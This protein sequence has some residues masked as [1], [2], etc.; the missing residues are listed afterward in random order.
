MKPKETTFQGVRRHL[1]NGYVILTTRGVVALYGAAMREAAKIVDSPVGVFLAPRDVF[2]DGPHFLRE[3]GLRATIGAMLRQTAATYDPP[4]GRRRNPVNDPL[5]EQ[6]INYYYSYDLT[7]PDGVVPSRRPANEMD[8]ALETPFA[9]APKP[10]RERPIAAIVHGFYPEIAPL[11]L[12]KLKNVTGPVD[13]FFSTDTQEKKRALE[14][15]CRDWPKGRVE[16]RICPNRG[17]DIAAKF[18][19]FRDVYADYDLFIHLH[20]KRSPHG[21]AA[22]ARWRDYLFDNLLGSPEIVNSILSLFDD[23]KIG[24]VFPQHLF[25]LRGILNWGYDYD[26]ARALMK[27]MGVEID[28]NLVLEFP[29]GS[30]FWGRSAAFRPLLDLDIDFDDFPEEGGQVDGTLAHAIERSLLM[31]AESRGFEWLKVARRDLYPM[32]QTLLPVHSKEELAKHRLKVFQPCLSNVDIILRPQDRGI[33]EIRP[34]LSYPSRNVR[35]RLNLLIPTVNPQQIFGGVATAIKLFTEIADAL[36]AEY[37]RRIV[38]TDADIEPEAYARLSDYTPVPYVASLDEG[39]RLLVDTYEREGGRLDLRANDIFIATAWWTAGF[40]AD[41]ERDRER[42]F[43]SK[44]PFIYLIQD[45]ETYFNGRSSRSALAEA[46]YRHGERMIAI[47]NSEELFSV[48]TGKYAFREAYFIPYEINR[49]IS[50]ALAEK[51]RERLLLVYGRPTVNR[52]AFELICDG[53]FRWQQRDPIRASRWRIVF[54]GED[55]P[56]TL[57]YP[58]VNASVG[59]KASLEG[60][61]DHLSRASVGVSIMI[62]PHP[63][64]PPLEMAEAGLTTI[65]NGFE[66]K[67]LQRRFDNILSL[68]R[69]DPASLADAIESAVA[70]MEPRIGSIIARATPKT[71]PRDETRL[72]DLAA[73]AERLRAMRA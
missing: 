63:S 14:D 24:V 47:I 31:I 3:H 29:S 65:T 6:A 40:A 70:E 72:F 30:M 56:D 15:V 52:N 23:P 45:D 37:D 44:L 16:I 27:R 33:V 8:F 32:P 57:L 34:L 41:L 71:P 67:N 55:F 35:P 4:L 73:F 59:G 60:Y 54:L 39:A 9:F 2:R 42:L 19:G 68:E 64:Y 26:H 5:R 58:V 48:M 12:E 61:A 46:T 36:G 28:K 50:A 11:V 69:L 66:G 13:L 18:F 25:E 21:G 49:R 43:G 7:K 53:L 1:R 10:A 22:L 20:T 38:T 51:P 17:R 62:S